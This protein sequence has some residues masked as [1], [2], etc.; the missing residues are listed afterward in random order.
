MAKDSKKRAAGLKARAT[1]EKDIA[2]E[3]T[4]DVRLRES[5]LN[6]WAAQA[7]A[8]YAELMA[9]GIVKGATILVETAKKHRKP[10][11]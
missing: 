8:A 3:S 10:P 6:R 5:Q 4:N 11:A 7:A 1:V 9:L 2:D